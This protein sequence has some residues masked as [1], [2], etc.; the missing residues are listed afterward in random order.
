[1][2]SAS[3]FICIF[4]CGF[5]MNVG[6]SCLP[7]WAQDEP[8]DSLSASRIGGQSGQSYDHVTHDDGSAQAKERQDRHPGERIGGMDGRPYEHLKR[9]Y[10]SVPEKGRIGGDTGN[11]YN[12]IQR[13]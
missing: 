12:R 5:V 6:L 11:N 1:M 3:K 4:A 7:T 8:K 13:E 2:V 9:K 10:E